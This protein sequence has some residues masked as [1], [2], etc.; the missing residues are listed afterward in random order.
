MRSRSATILLLMVVFTCV[1][2]SALAA[3]PSL[4]FTEEE[5]AFIETHPEVLIGVD[6]DFIPFEFFSEKGIHRGIAADLLSLISKRSGF[7]FISDP[8]LTWADALTGAREGSIELLAAIGFTAER[9]EFLTYLE[10]YMNF[11]RSIVIQNSNT[12]ISSFD[13][14]A[15][16]QVAVQKESSHEGF[17]KDY[18]DIHLRTYDTV[19]DALLAVNR[20]EEV[21]FIGNEATSAYLSR[22]LGLSELKFITVNE[23][24]PQSLHIAVRSDLPLL[25]S[26]IQKSLDDIS[27][28]ELSSILASWIRYEQTFDY[29]S[30]IRSAVIILSLFLLTIFIS[31]FWIVRLRKV[32]KEKVAAQIRAEQADVQKGMFMARVSHEV[33]TPLN[34]IRGMSY[35]LE[36]TKLDPVQKRYL[37]AI[38]G[39]SET[40]QV[41]MED[42]LEYSRLEQGRTTIEHVAFRLDDILQDTLSIDSWMIREKG[43]ELKVQ[44]SLDVPPYLIGDPTRIRQILTNLLHNAVK[45]TESGEISLSLTTSETAET[46]CLLLIEIR[47]TGIGMSKEQLSRL[48][49]PFSQGDTS[50]NRRYGGSGLGLSI[51][52]GLLDAMN[53][54]VEVVSMEG[55]GSTFTVRIPLEIDQEGQARE[56]QLRMS[57]NFSQHR[58]LLVLPEKALSQQ[59]EALLARYGLAYESVSSFEML[60]PLL[61]QPHSYDLLIGELENLGSIP[62][63]FFD[64]LDSSP[65]DRP[66]IILFIHDIDPEVLQEAVMSERDIILPLPLI[67]S[68][69]FNALLQL[70]GT[71]DS[72][73]VPEMRQEET[74]RE[75]PLRVLVVEDNATN[76]MIVHELLESRGHTVLEAVDGKE[77]Y[78]LFLDQGDTLDVILMDLHMSRMNG[79]EATRL[80]RE[81]DSDIPILILSADLITSVEDQFHD[82]HVNGFLAKPYDPDELVTKTLQIARRREKASARSPVIDISLGISLM[83][84]NEQLYRSILSSFIDEFPPILQALRDS[85]ECS[86]TAAAAALLHRCK[87]SCGAIGAK[88]AHRLS[89]GSE[90]ILRESGSLPNTEVVSQLFRVLEQTLCEAR[91]YLTRTAP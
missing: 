39:S 55:K 9:A 16:R 3:G 21:A 74:R 76:R 43:L 50:I 91:E 77:A 14:L 69:F 82:L 20:G 15:G 36:K 48:F 54:T 8:E 42:I 68:I 41:I 73:P 1:S 49:N 5:R 37:Q 45:F 44:T 11:Q 52:K 22:T 86:D 40:A 64:A 90:K 57:V 88:E 28:N 34:G 75:N 4:S 87:G 61:S 78:E 26:I 19:Q 18:P 23:G 13:D 29:S 24:G 38:K 72:V 35:L 60:L 25:A 83:G 7:T 33:R 46:R 80:I 12:T 59:I 70:F 47:D 67:N 53:G 2:L 81:K 56:N 66:S 10:P 32:V 51:V 27:D 71:G 58:A 31:A 84:R 63:G 30:L 65:F 79:Y 89:V 6:P 85:V 62:A 17:L